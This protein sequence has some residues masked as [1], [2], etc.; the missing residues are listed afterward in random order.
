MRFILKEIFRNIRQMYLYITVLVLS[1]VFCFQILSSNQVRIENRRSLTDKNITAT[2]QFTDSY[3]SVYKDAVEILNK[4]KDIHIFDIKYKFPQNFNI[5]MNKRGEFR[6]NRFFYTMFKMNNKFQIYSGK[7]PDF[8]SDDLEISIPLTYSLNNEVKI[9][10]HIDINGTDL[11]VIGITDYTGGNNAFVIS[12]N[13]AKKLNMKAVEAEIKLKDDISKEERIKIYNEINNLMGENVFIDIDTSGGM[14]ESIPRMYPIITILLCLSIFNILFV[15]WNILNNR[16]R[17][18]FIYNFL[19]I[20]KR[21][22]YK[23][24]LS[25]VVIIYI[26]SFILACL[27]FVCIDSIILKNIFNLYRY[28]LKIEFVIFIFVLFLILLVIFTYFAIRKY[29]NKSVI[30]IYKEN[31]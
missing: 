26:L 20:K 3:K 1:T 18:Y 9:G 22:F 24:L 10:D 4:Y 5:E 16:K 21:Q 6:I 19:G 29:F 15:Y 17:R 30:E 27:I 2:Y 23:M 31:V 14:M 25:E 12:L 7:I 28:S 8:K 11:K 13:T